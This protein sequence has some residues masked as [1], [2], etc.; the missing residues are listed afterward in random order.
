LSAH[1]S[2]ERDAASFTVLPSQR[3]SSST[4]ASVAIVSPLAIPGRY[5]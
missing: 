4:K 1:A 5:A 2:P 3:P